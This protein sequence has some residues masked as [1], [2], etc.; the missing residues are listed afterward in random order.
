MGQEGNLGI[1]PVAISGSS[2][3]FSSRMG[4]PL[5]W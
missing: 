2:E 4:L 5:P 3:Y 1:Q